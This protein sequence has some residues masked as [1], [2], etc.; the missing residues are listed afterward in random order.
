MSLQPSR[1]G[2]QDRRLQLQARRPEKYNPRVEVDIKQEV[3][4]TNSPSLIASALQAIGMA[5]KSD[6][7]A[8][9]ADFEIIEE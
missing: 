3:T 5:K 6:N 9:D 1:E 4:L 7:E 8:E 2:F